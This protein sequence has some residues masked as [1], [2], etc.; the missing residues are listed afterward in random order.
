MI[1]ILM[2]TYNIQNSVYITELKKYI[3]PCHK[4]C[5]I[6]FSFRTN[7]IPS[8]EVWKTFY[9]KEM[10]IYR[11]GFE[12]MF[13]QFDIKKEQL[14]YINYFEDTP[15]SALKKCA[16][17]DI[18]YFTGGLPDKLYLR[19]QEF[20][21]VDYL[22]HHNKIIMGD[23]AGAVIQFREYHL[24]PDADYSKFSYYTGLD[25]LKNFNIEVHYTGSIAQ[26]ESIHKVTAEKHIPVLALID[27]S[28]IIAA[29][30][31][32]TCLGSVKTSFPN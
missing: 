1:N 11:H 23:S 6:P 2:N 7:D 20:N 22:S 13:F 5:V 25:M 27:D 4:V 12:R 19:L 10:G 8:N 24:S 32:I 16:N 14:T 3:K 26:D 17:S 28:I 31:N 30:N 15:D 18:V 21:L 9:S 29:N